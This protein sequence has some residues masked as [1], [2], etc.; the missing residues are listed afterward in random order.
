M[1]EL[2][3]FVLLDNIKLL[4]NFTHYFNYLR[5]DELNEFTNDNAFILMRKSVEFA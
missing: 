1:G 3:G 5:I 4:T 2:V